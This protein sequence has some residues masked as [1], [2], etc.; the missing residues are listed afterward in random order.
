[1]NWKVK[2]VAKSFRHYG[3]EARVIA[4]V[5]FSYNVVYKD[6]TTDWI[7]ADAFEIISKK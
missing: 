6:G 7:I 2:I 4:N 5:G 1:M 3:E